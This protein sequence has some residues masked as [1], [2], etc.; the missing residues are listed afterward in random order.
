MT[1]QEYEEL[2]ASRMAGSAF[3]NPVRRHEAQGIGVPEL[4]MFVP[5]LGTLRGQFREA[6]DLA[7]EFLSDVTSPEGYGHA[8]PLEVRQRASR[9]LAMLRPKEPPKCGVGYQEPPPARCE[10]CDSE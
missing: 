8:V 7:F 10:A 6:A 4:G 3:D 9:I 1:E 5:E 2:R